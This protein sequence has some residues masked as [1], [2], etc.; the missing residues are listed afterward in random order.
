MLVVCLVGKIHRWESLFVSFFE[1]RDIFALERFLVELQAKRTEFSFLLPPAFP[2]T[3]YLATFF[4]HRPSH[5]RQEIFSDHENADI[6]SVQHVHR[7]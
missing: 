5:I 6:D 2:P 7:I 3:S 4:L 1:W